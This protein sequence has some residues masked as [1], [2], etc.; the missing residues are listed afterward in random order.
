[1]QLAHVALSLGLFS[2]VHAHA[3][4]P[5]RLFGVRH[6]PSLKR[7]EPQPGDTLYLNAPACDFYQCS[8]NY[9][10]GDLVAV[11][12]LN[13]PKNGNVQIALMTDNSEKLAYN[14][15]TAP[16]TI[17]TNFCDSDNGLGVPVKGRTCGRAE[18]KMPSFVETGNYTVRVTSL[19]PA[20]YQDTYTD[21]VLVKKTKNDV[22]LQLLPIKG[23]DGSTYTP[24]GEG[25]PSGS[26]GSTTPSAST[27]APAA[28]AT[29]PS[30]ATTTPMQP[31]ATAANTTMSG[32]PSNSTNTSQTGGSN[33]GV[34]SPSQMLPIA[35]SVGSAVMAAAWFGV[36]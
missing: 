27:S 22:P 4:E 7:Q 32:K 9:T 8:V 12:W 25:Y 6:A 21:V 14:I 20:P 15:T 29:K 35:F 33:A 19:P 16:P 34:G 1:M 31:A 11:N 5:R 2:L 30:T 3:H 26:S 28:G 23:A 17:P 10:T 13:A 18:F 36:L 24:S